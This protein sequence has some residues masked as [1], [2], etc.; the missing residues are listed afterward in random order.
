MDLLIYGAGAAGE[1]IYDL[2]V[3]NEMMNHRYSN[4]R[5][6][7]DEEY[8]TGEH[9]YNAESIPYLSIKKSCEEQQEMIIGV[10][11]PTARKKMYDK[12]VADGY[13]LATLIDKTAT[14][15]DTAI[16]SEGSVVYAGAVISS[17]AVIRPNCMIMFH[18]IIGHHADVGSSC[19]V[20]PKA[21]VGGFSKVG[22]QSFIGLGSSMLQHVNIGSKAIVGLGSMVFRD[23]A[24]ESVVIGNPARVTK[25]NDNH[26]VF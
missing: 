22:E 5:F 19:V 7:V 17:E 15:S 14:V 26:K 11:E 2:V 21:T 13:K 3:R 25:G 23:V 12:I 4:I 18:S 6:V 20:S 10:G 9:I 16:I 1:E 8:Y 24:D